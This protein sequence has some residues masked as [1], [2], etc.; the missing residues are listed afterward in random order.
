MYTYY[1]NIN[2]KQPN[3]P[4]STVNTFIVILIYNCCLYVYIEDQNPEEP[5]TLIYYCSIYSG[6]EFLLLSLSMIIIK[7]VKLKA[8]EMIQNDNFEEYTEEAELAMS[9]IR[10][11]PQE[12]D[13]D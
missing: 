2:E 6:V 1:G 8:S 4:M 13:S 9:E 10:Y 5:A 12:F 3:H 7:V 11:L